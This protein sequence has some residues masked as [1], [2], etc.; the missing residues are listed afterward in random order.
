MAYKS[1]KHPDQD[2]VAHADKIF[3]VSRIHSAFV[4]TESIT[5]GNQKWVAV[6]SP[7]QPQAGTL[8]SPV[9]A[10]NF[11]SCTFQSA[12]VSDP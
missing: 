3:A 9:G 2:A 8:D 1:I 11:V 12:P 5:G 7:V 6:S 10:Q 4:C